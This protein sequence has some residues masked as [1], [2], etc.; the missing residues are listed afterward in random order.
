MNE[1]A[2]AIIG[3]GYIGRAVGEALLRRGRRVIG[4]TTTPE[5]SQELADLG[6]EPRVLTVQ[7]TDTMAEVVRPCETVYLTVA[8]G[9]RHRDYREI[10]LR[11]VQ[12]LLKAVHGTAV[13][14][15]LYTSSTGVYGRQDGS[16][17]D[18]DSPTEPATENGRVLAETEQ[19]LLDGAAKRDIQA[20]IARLSGIVGP[21]R[22]P[23]NRMPSVAGQTR[24]DG[25]AWVNLIHSE[26]AVNVLVRLLDV[27]YHGVLNV[28]SP[29]PIR[30][31]EYYDRLIRQLGL[32]PIQWRDTGASPQGK[33]VSSR[34]L[35]DLLDYTFVHP[36]PES[37]S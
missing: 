24:E 18:E 21:G 5:R 11:G 17:V 22:G 35:V 4:T 29:E 1:K 25:D 32:A 15:I 20:T 19:T 36:R 23:V 30:R 14:R 13:R 10:Y 6:I 8:A 33:R 37:T 3:C 27:P 7:D 2:V 28:S 9:G 16:V 31:R 12:S 34:R 26:D